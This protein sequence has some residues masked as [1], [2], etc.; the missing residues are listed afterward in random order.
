MV[1]RRGV[2]SGVYWSRVED[3]SRSEYKFSTGHGSL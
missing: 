2:G 3:V 1:C